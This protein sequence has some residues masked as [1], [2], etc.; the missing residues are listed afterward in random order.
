MNTKSVLRE[1]RRKAVVE[2]IVI[3]REPV[4]LVRR[5]YNIPERTVFD[6]LSLY[7]AGGWDALK[8]GKRSGR[9]RK[10]SA[11]D[12]Q[13]VYNAV[14]LGNP[15]NYQFDFCLWTLNVLRTLIE[16]ERGIKLSKSAVSRLLGHLGLSPQRPIYK[17]YKQDPVKVEAYLSKTFPEA[18]AQAKAL[19]AEIFFVDEASVRSDAHRGLTWGKVGETPVVRDSGGRFGLN[20]ISAVSPR[21]D[22]RFSFVE[23]NMN[24][25]GFIRF[26]K[27]LH[28]DAGKPILV[29]TDNARYHR[30]EETQQFIDATDRQIVLVYLP[31]YSPELNPDEQVWNHGKAQLAKRLIFT[32]DDMKQQLFS[33]LY[34]IQKRVSLVKSFFRMPDAKYILAAL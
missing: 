13:W 22:M 17:S 11:E 30:S 8:E 12:M 10:L 9:P 23:G 21:G 31:P 32:K 15:L 20:V 6:W 29:I 7:R 14:T 19:K 16:T 24:S 34:S 1:E 18:V 5:I 33:I 27:K 3:R 25:V 26:L 28:K 4:H 2:A